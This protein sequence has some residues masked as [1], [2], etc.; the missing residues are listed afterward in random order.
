LNI[1]TRRL[2]VRLAVLL[3]LLSAGFVAWRT[4]ATPDERAIRSRL[5]SLRDEVN[6]GAKDGIAPGLQA[7][8]IASYFTDDAMVELGERSAPIRG[9]ETLIAMISRLQPGTVRLDLD[10][11]TIEMGTGTDAADVLLTATFTRPKNTRGQQ[12]LDAREFALVMSKSDS[13]WRISRVTAI[14]ALR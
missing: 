11:V 7:A 12:S 1:E 4:R 14:D 5:D 2:F 8:K 10:D 3:V 9:R 13:T 6:A